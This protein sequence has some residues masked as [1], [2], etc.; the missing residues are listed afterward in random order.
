MKHKLLFFVILF[1]LLIMILP[2]LIADGASGKDRL[3]NGFLLNPI[4]GNSYLAKMRIGW[5]GDWVFR[6][7]YTANPGNGG[8][9][10]LFY[11]YLGHL[12]R[13][14]NLSLV[15]TFH[16]ARVLA[17]LLLIVT[18]YHFCNKSFQTTSKWNR[19]SFL[20]VSLG[21]GLGWLLFP[22]GLVTSD[23][24]VPEA[25]P[26]LSEYV[27]PHFPLGLGLLLWIFLWSG[28]SG[29]KTHFAIL[30]FGL[31]LAV[32]QPFAVVIGGLVLV[33]MA[34][35]NWI[36][37]HK[38]VWKPPF[39][40]LI[41]GGPFLVY[42][43]WISTSDPIL[44]GWNAQNQTLSPPILDLVIAFSPALILA[45]WTFFR[46]RTWQLNYYQK[47]AVVWFISSLVLILV[48]FS[49]QRRFLMGFF[50]PVVILACIG[51]SQ[52]ASSSK[53]QRRIFTYSFAISIPTMLVI[54]LLAAFG[55]STRNES[56]FRSVP[57]QQAFTWL[58]AYAPA[59]SII[60]SAP[61]TGNLIPIYSG[62]R[63]LYGHP[64]ETVNADNMK[65]QVSDFFNG[66]LSTDAALKLIRDLHV[67]YIFFGP[68]EKK[69][70]SP[71]I[72]NKLQP[73]FDN[74]DVTIFA[75]N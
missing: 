36:E 60:L 62:Q 15:T 14:M 12:A 26:L 35:W 74:S 59:N 52:L 33:G 55:I 64:F 69:L 6:L 16:L 5:D 41:G 28:Q 11:I 8:Y 37:T 43:F 71:D 61:D 40:F 53:S 67:G 57:E 24:S 27:N 51:I 30:V 42:Q 46:F 20:W 32:I 13:F 39:F 31:A 7:P 10:F 44:G 50:V 18:I 68:R 3:F 58:E 47:I 73:V 56:L 70:G 65:M 34:G 38:L 72:L 54:L 48:P 4:D 19:W 49:L 63:V 29:Y 2:F 23:I 75:V 45:V 25:Y 17:G 21:S 9:L 1:S 22:F 66:K